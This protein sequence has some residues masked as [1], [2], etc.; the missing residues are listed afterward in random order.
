MPEYATYH[1][2]IT[3]ITPLHIGNGVTLLHEYDYAIHAGRTW[4][5]DNSA[6]L[7]A[8]QIDDPAFVETLATTPPARLLQ[9]ND[10]T[11]E[12]PFFHYVIRGTPRSGAEGAQLQEQLKDAY[13][14]PYLPGSSLKGAFRTALGW[15]M[16]KDL[17]LR[18][19]M[20]LL[21]RSPKW[22]AQSYERTIFGDTPNQDVLRA[23]QVS[24]SQP[25][26][27]ERLMV[28]NVRVL[29]RS[30]SLKSPIELEAIRPETNFEAD[31]KL[32]LALFSGWAKKHNLRLGGS[33]A[34]EALP[35]IANTR[36]LLRAK[37]ELA[38]FASIP[39][40]A[41]V[42]GFYEQL[43]KIQPEDNQF[44]LQLGWGTGWEDKTFG[45]CLS[46]DERFFSQVVSEYRMARGKNRG[47]GPFPSSRRVAVAYRKDARE[48]ITETP[49]YPLG[50][51][52]VTFEE[53]HGQGGGWRETNKV[54]ASMEAA[55]KPA[56]TE[57]G[58]RTP[59]AAPA[60][61]SL[62]SEKPGRPAPVPKPVERP[63]RPP[64]V[65]R[66]TA[67]PEPGQR[68]YGT[69][70]EIGAKQV[71]LELPGLSADEWFG[72]IETPRR[73]LTE[74][75]QAVCEVERVEPDPLNKGAWIV[76]CKLI[77]ED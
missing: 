65:R 6:F 41:R 40:A 39:N 48:N 8:Q 62:T 66:F 10:Y 53:V 68:F 55:P 67:R 23:M 54:Q 3:T 73:K 60:G 38:W 28:L 18:P 9:D 27:P 43:S 17:G 61:P 15:Q 1:L 72:L 5:I 52:L 25:V 58:A 69:V 42:R 75:E 4:R 59:A 12:S 45:D 74:A 32:D 51:V 14:R 64:V 30:G 35:A 70:L 49:A 63:S 19:E 13:N 57:V 11:L 33:K 24:D 26:P 37:K 71:S 56:T 22:A 50:W 21:N 47:E 34:L 44:V 76:R 2:T 29:G 20:R 36:T 46:Q 31:V 7:D 77:D 16:W